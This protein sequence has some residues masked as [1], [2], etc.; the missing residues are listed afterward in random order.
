VSDDEIEAA[1]AVHQAAIEAL[2]ELRR[3]RVPMMSASAAVRTR[4]IAERR[5]ELAA[6][7]FKNFP[8]ES[9]TVCRICA[10]HPDWAARLTKGAWYVDV[11]LFTEF[12]GR[13][14]R[15]EESFGVSALSAKSVANAPQMNKDEYIGNSITDEND[16]DQNRET[17]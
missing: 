16:D 14:Q 11:D 5:W 12:A 4:P 17:A 15:G 7:A 9:H 10:S 8:F 13:V 3:V 6:R 2:R 1:I